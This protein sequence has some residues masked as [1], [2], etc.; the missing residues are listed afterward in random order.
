[1]RG[2]EMTNVF[3]GVYMTRKDIARGFRAFRDTKPDPL[4]VAVE[5]LRMRLDGRLANRGGYPAVIGMGLPDVV[6]VADVEHDDAPTLEIYSR[7]VL[8]VIGEAVL[9]D[10]VRFF[11]E[12]DDPDE[13]IDWMEYIWEHID[14]ENAEYRGTTEG[15]R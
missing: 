1:F 14:F 15:D 11:A 8:T 12:S 2:G 5:V 6:V 9:E 10:A 3:P 7:D 13:P 4:T